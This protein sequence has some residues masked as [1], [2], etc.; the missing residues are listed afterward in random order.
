MTFFNLEAFWNCRISAVSFCLFNQQVSRWVC[1]TFAGSVVPRQF[2]FPFSHIFPLYYSAP[3]FLQPYLNTAITE[4]WEILEQPVYNTPPMAQAQHC[5]Q[6]D[7]GET[8]KSLREQESLAAWAEVCCPGLWWN[9]V[10]TF[11]CKYLSATVKFPN[12]YHVLLRN[13]KHFCTS[14]SFLFQ[15]H[16]SFTTKNVWCSSKK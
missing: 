10:V 5:S 14:F 9:K 1:F 3:I 13:H 15:H 11:D 4:H 6:Q 8:V 12:Q 2:H 7:E 16:V